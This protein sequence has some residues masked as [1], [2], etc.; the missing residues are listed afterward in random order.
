[1]HGRPAPP[2]AAHGRRARRP[3]VDEAAATGSAAPLVKRRRRRGAASAAGPATSPPTTWSPSCWRALPASAT[4]AARGAQR[5]RRRRA[6]QP[7][8]GAA[9]G[10]PPS[11]RSTVAAGATDVELDL[12]TGRRG[13]RGRGRAAALAAAVPDAGGVHVVNNGAAALALVDLRAGRRPRGRGGPRR[14]GRDRRRLPDPRAAG[15]GRARGCA[16]SARRTGCGSRTTQ[17]AVG[18]RNRVRAQGAPVELP[19]RGVHLLGAGRRARDARRC[20]WWPTSARAC[21]RRTRGCPTS[22]TPRRASAPGADLVTASGDK[23]L[24]GPQCGLLL[25]DADLVRAAAARTRSRGRCAST[26]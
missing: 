23:L 6:H 2:Y 15:V 10:A 14:D 4:V 21:S 20:R 9:V 16:R 5:D 26:S 11:T 18:D 19:G 24:G 12:A 13:P 3:G 17:A 25:G 22:R 1:M 7:R 8:P